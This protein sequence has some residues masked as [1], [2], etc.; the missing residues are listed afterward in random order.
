MA[1]WDPPEPANGIITAYGIYCRLSE[2]NLFTLQEV[3]GPQSLVTTLD[4]LISF[5]SYVCV[6]TANTSAGEGLM[7][8]PQTAATDQDGEFVYA[9][10]QVHS[11]VIDTAW[12][13]A[14]YGLYSTNPQRAQPRR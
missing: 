2:G 9:C 4:S 3:V 6:V 7:S 13:S 11:H 12:Q 8:D 10:I 5:T 1:A 14:L